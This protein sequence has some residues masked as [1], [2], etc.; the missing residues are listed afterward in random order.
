MPAG[1]RALLC[2]SSMD[3]YPE[4]LRAPPQPVVALVRL[5]H[6]HA[7]LAQQ[8]ATLGLRVMSVPD[9][10]RGFPPEAK[11]HKPLA[12]YES[13]QATGILKRSWVMK[14]CNQMA[15][16]IIL[17][18]EW[19]EDANW[20]VVEQSVGQRIDAIK[21]ATRHRPIRI[22]CCR[23][24][25][26]SG[27]KLDEREDKERA[28]S[29][30]R[31]TDLQPNCFISILIDATLQAAR[32]VHTMAREL[33]NMAYKDEAR[34]L[35]RVHGLRIPLS[36]PPT[37]RCSLYSCP[38]ATGMPTRA[39]LALSG[40]IG[41]Q[42]LSGWLGRPHPVQSRVVRRVQARLALGRQQLQA[43]LRPADRLSQPVP[44]CVSRP[45]STPADPPFQSQHAE[46]PGSGCLHRPILN[47]LSLNRGETAAC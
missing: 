10:D 43:G 3:T 12:H 37:S 35:K 42:D 40:R 17:L 47:A 16:V 5:H 26:T 46:R 22:L 19:E 11:E 14:R 2:S 9:E 27:P 15:V 18:F 45:G 33:A 20:K 44:G 29:F 4:E 39:G 41:G 23:V 31:R 1:N 8:L 30:R 38:Q 24:Q 36:A 21:Q 32:K 34:R 6:L 28:M 13:Y 7:P 25:H